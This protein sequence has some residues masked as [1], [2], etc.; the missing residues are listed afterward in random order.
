MILLSVTSAFCIVGN[1]HILIICITFVI[2]CIIRACVKKWHMKKYRKITHS[3]LHWETKTNTDTDT[4]K[5]RYAIFSPKVTE[6]LVFLSAGMLAL[7]KSNVLKLI[8]RLSLSPGEG[9]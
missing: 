2:I 1:V 8:K 6:F 4:L 9:T 3:S 7:G 5:E